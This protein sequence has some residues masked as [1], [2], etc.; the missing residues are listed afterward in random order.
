MCVCVCVCVCVCRVSSRK[1]S[2]RGQ[3]TIFKISEGA[4]GCS[5]QKIT[6][7][8]NLIRGNKIQLGGAVSPP[9]GS[10]AAPRE[11]LDF[12]LFCRQNLYILPY[13]N[14][15]NTIIMKHACT[16]VGSRSLCSWAG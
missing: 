1:I 2:M 8:A 12:M 5:R 15:Y 11:N 16:I 13:I 9:V 6:S 10:G 14:H 7:P 3:I 4:Q